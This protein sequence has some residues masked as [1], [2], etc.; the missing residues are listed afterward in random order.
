MFSLSRGGPGRAPEERGTTT[1]WRPA[2][3]H[4]SVR[5]SPPL[6]RRQRRRGEHRKRPL[7]RS[8]LSFHSSKL[9][10]KPRQEGVFSLYF[11]LELLFQS[12]MEF[13]AITVSFT[14]TTDTRFF[15]FS[16]PFTSS[17]WRREQQR[18]SDSASDGKETRNDSTQGNAKTHKYGNLWNTID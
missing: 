2:E 15:P 4:R 8:E 1:A 6:L 12:R 13:S 11:S 10:H 9:G 3:S 17:C 14:G 7:W 5:R 16:C 18:R